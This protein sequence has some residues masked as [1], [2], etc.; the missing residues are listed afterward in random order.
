MLW[1]FIRLLFLLSP[2]SLYLL[3]CG[4]SRRRARRKRRDRRRWEA[5]GRQRQRRR[6]REATKSLN[7]AF[8]AIIRVLAKYMRFSSRA[9]QVSHALLGLKMQPKR[10]KT[11]QG[12]ARKPPRRYKRPPRMLQDGQRGA[13]DSPK[14]DSKW[15]PQRRELSHHTVPFLH[16]TCTGQPPSRGIVGGVFRS[17]FL[18]RTWTYFYAC[19]RPPGPQDAAKTA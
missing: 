16:R 19:I 15:I 5:R 7:K 18:D 10:L 17:V 12:R 11:A 6:R 4:R 3:L 13:Q 14:E 9:R 1:G 8:S 2:T